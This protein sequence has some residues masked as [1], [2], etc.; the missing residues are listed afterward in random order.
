MVTRS[1]MEGESEALLRCFED[2]SVFVGDLDNL[3]GKERLL[4][5]VGPG[6]CIDVTFRVLRNIGRENVHAS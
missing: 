6:N 4:L 2:V 1:E 5:K 3:F